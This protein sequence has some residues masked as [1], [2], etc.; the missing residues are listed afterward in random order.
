MKIRSVSGMACRVFLFFLLA[1]PLL[2][3]LFQ[4]LLHDNPQ[5]YPSVTVR[6]YEVCSIPARAHLVILVRHNLQLPASCLVVSG[7]TDDVAFLLTQV[8]V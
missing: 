6:C 5:N 4:H 2:R 1:G 7:T 8:Q 3:N